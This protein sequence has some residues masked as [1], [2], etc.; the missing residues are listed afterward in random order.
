MNTTRVP[1]PWEDVDMSES[2]NK[3]KLITVVAILLCLG[4]GGLLFSSNMLLREGFVTFHPKS[5]HMNRMEMTIPYGVYIYKY[6]LIPSNRK[7]ATFGMGRGSLGDSATLFGKSASSSNNY[8]ARGTF[9]I[10]LETHVKLSKKLYTIAM[11][12]MPKNRQVRERCG[13]Y[14]F[15]SKKKYSEKAFRKMVSTWTLKNGPW[16]QK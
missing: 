16:S 2:T 13:L 7:G 9:R 10:P 15:L 1:F 5:K 3:S 4:V 12:K 11:M 6:H 14:L 8:P